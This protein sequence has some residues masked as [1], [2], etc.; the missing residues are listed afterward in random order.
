MIVGSFMKSLKEYIYEVSLTE[1]SLTEG[2]LDRVKNKEVNHEVLVKEFL[3]TNYE[4]DG[5]Y[6]IKD[7]NKGFV[8]DINGDIDVK[9]ENIVTLTNEFFKFGVV[10]GSF[11]CRGCKSL[12][13][14]KGAPQK[15][16]NDF[17]CSGCDSLKTLIGAPEKVG[18][19]F[20]CFSCKSLTTLEGA[21]EKVDGDFYCSHCYKLKSLKGAPKE[22]GGGFYC[23]DSEVKFSRDD[24]KKYTAVTGVIILS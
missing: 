24:V 5:S 13:T 10:S 15:V 23:R 18:W 6:T 11:D 20:N 16:S 22:V 19:D 4:I 2:L 1:G 8:V 21:P 17:N 14:L 7:T 3:E 9:N 12:K